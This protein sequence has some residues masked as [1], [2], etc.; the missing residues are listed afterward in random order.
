MQ[1]CEL[2]GQ[3][4]KFIA[5]RHDDVIMCDAEPRTVITGNGRRLE[6]YLPHVCGE[7]KDGRTEDGREDG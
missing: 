5:V 4:V 6:A 7:G 1:M 3:P 2:C